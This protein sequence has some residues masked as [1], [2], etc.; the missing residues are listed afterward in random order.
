MESKQTEE[1]ILQAAEKLFLEQGFKETTTSQIAK[2][3]GCNSALVHY[4]FR[5]KENLFAK[6]FTSKVEAYAQGMFGEL[7]GI[8]SIEQLIRHGVEAHWKFMAAN[9]NL[10]LFMIREVLEMNDRTR[11]FIERH[12]E[13]RQQTSEKIA[14]LM[15]KE[16][17][18][19]H[20]CAISAERL[21]QLILSLDTSYFF[22]L[23]IRSKA[24]G[25]PLDEEEMK[26]EREEAIRTILARL[27]YHE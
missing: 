26:Q 16:A 1:V 5:T 6:V 17:A 9:A 2:A 20:T 27:S 21:L 18:L 14:V 10:A 4:Y 19:G 22:P 11:H 13:L 7:E 15:A 12:M 8:E 3:A 23:V 25:T 24:L